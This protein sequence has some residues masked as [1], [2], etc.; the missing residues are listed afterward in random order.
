MFFSV[1]DEKYSPRPIF[2]VISKNTVFL[3][4][5]QH[6]MANDKEEEEYMSN[7]GDF[8][9]VS[10]IIFAQD[11]KA[12]QQHL[13]LNDDT[14]QNDLGVKLN[15]FQEYFYE[16]S[17]LLKKYPQPKHILI[18]L[19]NLEGLVSLYL[20]CDVFYQKNILETRRELSLGTLGD[21]DRKVY[22]K[23]MK[24]KEDLWALLSMFFKGAIYSTEMFIN[25]GPYSRRVRGS[26]FKLLKNSMSMYEQKE[27]QYP[28]EIEKIRFLNMNAVVEFLVNY[29]G[30]LDTHEQDFREHLFDETF[31]ALTQLIKTT[32]L[33]GNSYLL[34]DFF[35]SDKSENDVLNPFIRLEALRKSSTNY[36]TIR[37]Y[38]RYLGYNLTILSFSGENKINQDLTIQADSCY[39]I[40]LNLPAWNG[41]A[42]N[43]KEPDSK[44]A[45]DGIEEPSNIEESSRALSFERQEF[46]L[47]FLL[48]YLL[49]L[50]NLKQIASP[51]TFFL[52]EVKFLVSTLLE[53]ISTQ[54]KETAFN[55]SLSSFSCA[56]IESN[57]TAFDL[58]DSRVNGISSILLHGSYKEKWVLIQFFDQFQ[59]R[60]ANLAGL[61]GSLESNLCFGLRNL[62]TILDINLFPGKGLFLKA[63]KNISKL[64]KA[65]G[66]KHF[67]LKSGLKGVPETYLNKQL[68]LSVPLANY[69]DIKE[70]VGIKLK[71]KNYETFA[72]L[73]CT[74]YLD[75]EAL[76]KD[77]RKQNEINKITK[78]LETSSVSLK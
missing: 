58:K 10:E 6:K 70:S 77:A 59:R 54:I 1:Y 45:E 22:G 76:K 26:L 14:S 17:S 32:Y 39:K 5:L 55:S 2:Y 25:P 64:L 12:K 29:Y 67:L 28:A 41:V 16:T 9:H 72:D 30:Y 53:N 24:I 31:E 13:L 18:W 44:L 38:Y 43:G 50:T 71:E 8:G 68:H 65:I 63:L 36:Q 61:T 35:D 49:K 60:G 47:M 73:D 34:K 19:F 15:R 40:L 23:L 37:D 33:T 57:V 75:A 78:Y 20:F 27:F 4:I 62:E 46:S 69:F 52:V 42:L 74:E 66:V 56:R 48:N 3:E 51:E 11:K 21:Q 7:I